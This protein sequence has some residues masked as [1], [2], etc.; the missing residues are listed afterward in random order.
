MA[1][2]KKEKYNLYLKNVLIENYKSIQLAE[3][4]LKPGLNII[5]G[6]NSSGKTNFI[7]CLDEILNFSDAPSDTSSKIKLIGRNEE[8][9]ISSSPNTTQFADFDK[10]DEL[11]FDKNNIAYS[12][13]ISGKNIELDDSDINVSLWNNKYF[14]ASNL[15][16]H[17]HPYNLMEFVAIPF[18]AMIV[19]N[20]KIS[21]ELYRRSNKYTSFLGKYF[22][23]LFRVLAAR[24]QNKIKTELS[25]NDIRN[26]LTKNSE[27]Y[28]SLLNSILFKYSPIKRIRVN[29]DFNLIEDKN[30]NRITLT[31]YILEFNINNNWIPFNLLSDG[32]KRL[33]Y[34]LS[35]LVGLE[36]NEADEESI[37]IELLEEP[38]LGIHPHQLHKLMLFIK[39]QSQSK[40]IVITTHSPQ[41][42]DLL[43]DNELDRIIICYYDEFKGTKFRH[44]SISQIAKAKLYME[45][46]FLSDYWRFSNLESTDI[47]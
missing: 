21:N 10:P 34:L 37:F 22:F 3:V 24:Q 17:G 36:E 2:K 41:V 30:S 9:D 38:E 29:E 31:N 16:E 26:V 18:S 28:F 7:S 8:I 25:V 11:A 12:L 47:V 40:Q 6:N 46:G 20:G 23:R 42:L 1:N 5:I 4:I 33:F 27:N 43:D 35:E 44:L 39:E 13:T 19:N 45:S 15:I 32:T 14:I